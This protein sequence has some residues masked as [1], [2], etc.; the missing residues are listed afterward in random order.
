MNMEQMRLF[1]QMREDLQSLQLRVKD[2][3]SELERRRSRPR[4][5]TNAVR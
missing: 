3:E 4:K 2:L 1:K 5:K